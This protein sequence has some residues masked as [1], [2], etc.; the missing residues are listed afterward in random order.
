MKRQGYGIVMPTAYGNGH[1]DDVPRWPSRFM[2][3][4]PDSHLGQAY[5]DAATKEGLHFGIYLGEMELLRNGGREPSLLLV[6]EAYRALQP[7]AIYF[8][9]AGRNFPMSEAIYSRLRAFDEN[10]IIKNGRPTIGHYDWDFLSWEGFPAHE[11]GHWFDRWPQEEPWFKQHKAESWRYI[12]D[13]AIPVPGSVIKAQTRWEDVVPVMLTL[14]G[15][16]HLANIDHSETQTPEDT[17]SANR[18]L[19]ENIARWASPAGKPSLTE[20]YRDVEIGPLAAER[21]GYQM[22]SSDRRTLYLYIFHSE[23]G[24]TGM[25]ADGKLELHGCAIPAKSVQVMN[26]D[27]HVDF[28]Q[29]GELIRFTVPPALVNPVATIIKISLASPHPAGRQPISPGVLDHQANGRRNLA[30]KKPTRMLTPD[31]KQDLGPSGYNLARGAVD[32][33][34]STVATAA[35]S[36]AWTLEVDLESAQPATGLHLIFSP[37]GY[38]TSFTIQ[39]SLDSQKWDTLFEKADGSG[40]AVDLPFK[41]TCRYYR[42]NAR[43]PDGENQTGGQM[44]VQELLIY[45]EAH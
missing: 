11:P 42:V 29:T 38:P 5:K 6:D 1:R 9:H 15:E 25:P 37:H 10:I 13:I 27:Q 23:A 40:A 26:A 14:V 39:A 28:E 34:R 7:K 31:A 2:P 18:Q 20:A 41:G 44:S 35:N 43:K 19:H 3:D 21:W 4:N 32:G 17:S 22:I 12:P 33:H 16:G 30:Y 8:D 24:R 36:W 45:G